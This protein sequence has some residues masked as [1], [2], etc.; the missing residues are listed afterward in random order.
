MISY[1]SLQK[2]H[3]GPA[4]EKQI[5]V[6]TARTIDLEKKILQLKEEVIKLKT[7]NFI[8]TQKIKMD[9]EK[10]LTLNQEKTK[11]LANLEIGT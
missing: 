5:E 10:L 1:L 7:E 2:G 6:L 3:S 8:L 11:L 4:L 9:H